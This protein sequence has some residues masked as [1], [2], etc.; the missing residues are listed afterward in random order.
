MQYF[1]QI[2]ENIDKEQEKKVKIQSQPH[3]FKVGEIL[4]DSWGY[5]QTNID[6]YQITR[7]SKGCIW[8]REIN[9]E[10]VKDTSYDSDQ[11]IPCKNK[12]IGEEKKKRVVRTSWKPEG[13]ISSDISGTLSQYDGTPKHRSWGHWPLCLTRHCPKGHPC[14]Q[15]PYYRFGQSGGWCFS[16]LS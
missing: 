9:L 4:Y 8:I 13:Y 6:F 1:A 12:F 2:K 3:N 5:D 15:A 10:S 14:L 11:V 16:G 7:I